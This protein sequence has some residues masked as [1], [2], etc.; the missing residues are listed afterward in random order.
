WRTKPFSVQGSE[1]LPILVR[2]RS[3]Y[4]QLGVVAFY[5]NNLIHITNDYFP[6][7][8]LIHIGLWDFLQK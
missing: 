7:F 2:F 3:G 8:F 6:K 5:S 4:A 1:Q